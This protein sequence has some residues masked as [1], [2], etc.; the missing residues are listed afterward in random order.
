MKIEVKDILGTIVALSAFAT[1]FIQYHEK[2][3]ERSEKE[4]KADTLQLLI[5][6]HNEQNEKLTAFFA[7]LDSTDKLH[8]VA[9]T[10]GE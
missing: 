4:A 5:Q 8:A 7:A 6:K 1:A 3:I 9:D 10:T 2:K